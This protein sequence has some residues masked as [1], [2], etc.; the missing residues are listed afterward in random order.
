MIYVQKMDYK[1]LVTC[2]IFVCIGCV[3]TAIICNGFRTAA[4]VETDI[5]VQR[6]TTESQ[7]LKAK[8][9]T[10]EGKLEAIIAGVAKGIHRINTI[11]DRISNDIDVVEYSIR[12]ADEI[13]KLAYGIESIITGRTE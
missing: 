5:L 3:V 6:L 9:A 10:A 13:G 4:E 11:G 2:L 1:S 8:L 7:Y 12:L